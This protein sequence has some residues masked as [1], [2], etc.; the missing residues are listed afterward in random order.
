MTQELLVQVGRQALITV[1]LVAGPALMAG[2]AVGLIVSVFQAVTQI[3]EFTLTF[4]PKILTVL[5]VFV[6]A[7]PWM[8]N[9]LLNFIVNLY[10][11]FQPLTR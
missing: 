10:S 5:T 9:T 8:L 4:V 2:M 1:L 11:D 6:I 7:M 3:Q